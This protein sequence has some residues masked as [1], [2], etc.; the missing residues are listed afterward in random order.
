MK[1][2]KMNLQ[3]TKEIRVVL[4]SILKDNEIL[5]QNNIDVNVG[6][7]TYNDDIATYKVEVNI[8]GGKSKKEVLLQRQKD[9]LE[10]ILNNSDEIQLE[11]KDGKYKLIGY[12][13]QNKKYPYII[14]D[15]PKNDKS[16]K[17]SHQQMRNLFAK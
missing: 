6:Q 13:S 2:T 11:S 10:D 12:K 9:D 3:S 16:Y 5:K 15:I 4:N 14:E 1:I 7:C 17:I 8:I